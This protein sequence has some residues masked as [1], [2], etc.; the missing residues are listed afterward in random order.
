MSLKHKVFN[1]TLWASA[2]QVLS[3]VC[4]FALTIVLARG[5]SPTDYGYFFVALNTVVIMVNVGMIGMDRVVVRF[6][7]MRIAHQDQAGLPRLVL[8]CFGMVLLGAGITCLGFALFARKFFSGLL[9]MP[10]LILYLGVITAWMFSATAQGQLTETFRGLNDIRFASLF[11]GV[12]SNGILNALIVTFLAAAFWLTGYLTLSIALSI[13]LATSILI[14][15]IALITLAWL[16]RNARE[17][18]AAVSQTPAWS[19]RNAL[20][21]G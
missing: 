6:A 18:G 14:V 15:C 1:G 5:L 13:M 7:S 20:Q 17:S 19:A 21:E 9:N 10:G 4:S 16:L 11:G 8:S 3:M 2:G 12:R